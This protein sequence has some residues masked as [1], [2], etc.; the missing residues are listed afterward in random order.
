[1]YTSI[2]SLVLWGI[3]FLEKYSLMF[4]RIAFDSFEHIYF[5][6]TETQN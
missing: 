2:Y 6:E 3:G 1:M 5:F 4:G